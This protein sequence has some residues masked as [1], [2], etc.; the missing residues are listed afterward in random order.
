MVLGLQDALWRSKRV[1]AQLYHFGRRKASAWQVLCK[2][3]SVPANSGELLAP[4]CSLGALGA[5]WV[6]AGWLA[7]WLA[8]NAEAEGA[9]DEEAEAEGAEAEEAEAEGAEAVRAQR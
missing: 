5:L 7:G 9:E 8:G 2:G 6:P 1:S 3:F 4:K